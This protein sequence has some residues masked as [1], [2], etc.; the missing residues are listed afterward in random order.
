MS[1]ALGYIVKNEAAWL[2]RLLPDFGFAFDGVVA[3][4]SGS[5]DDTVG[6]LERYGARV[7]PYQW[8]NNFAAARNAL[9]TLAEGCGYDYLLMLDGDEAMWPQ[10]V[11][12][13][14]KTAL[15][16]TVL[17]FPRFNFSGPRAE[18]WHPDLY[19]DTQWRLL[20]LRVGWGYRGAVHET[21]CRGKEVANL[22][23]LTVPYHIYHYGNCKPDEFVWL[24][25]HNYTLIAQGLPP[26]KEVPAH[27][28]P[29]DGLFPGGMK[30]SFHHPYHL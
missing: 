10:D 5:T 20:P 28:N 17:G 6:V 15:V 22:H 11:A 26:L 19:P 23:G 27:I 30:C 14:K 16:G 24:K 21:L 18:V 29:K 13:L 1:I 2:T 25:C 7:E 3:L 4:D 9:I 12:V 8:C